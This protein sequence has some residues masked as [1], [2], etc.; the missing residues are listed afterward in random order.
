MHNNSC[1]CSWKGIVLARTRIVELNFQTLEVARI[2]HSNFPP[3]C[4]QTND[5]HHHW[6]MTPRR[7]ENR[8]PSVVSPHDEVFCDDNVSS[9]EFSLRPSTCEDGSSRLV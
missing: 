4:Q 5:A 2:R 3:V 9:L 7:S 8:G 6:S 1:H